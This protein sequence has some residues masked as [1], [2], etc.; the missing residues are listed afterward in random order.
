MKLRDL[1]LEQRTIDG[2][3]FSGGALLCLAFYAWLSR[4]VEREA[5]ADQ[6]CVQVPYLV[7]TRSAC[8][9]VPA[10]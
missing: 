4:D 2:L 10:P 7:G 5:V 8:N 9:T 3:S 1:M 6:S